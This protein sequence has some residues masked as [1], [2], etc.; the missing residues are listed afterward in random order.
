MSAPVSDRPIVSRPAR[1]TRW[2]FDDLLGTLGGV[3]LP[4]G[5]ALVAL[6]WYGAAHTPYLFEQVP[7]LISG[8]VFGLG[9]MIVA[10]LL[11]VGSWVARTASAQRAATAEVLDLLRDIREEL[12]VRTPDV[13]AGRAAAPANGSRIRLVATRS[14]SMLH[15]PDCSVVAGRADLRRVDGRTSG[16]AACQLCDPLPAEPRVGRR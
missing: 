11:Y 5:L 15:R 12:A 8:G 3:L 4:L 14:G 1:R 10:A 2:A 13:S 6:G 9:V 7:Y 16:L